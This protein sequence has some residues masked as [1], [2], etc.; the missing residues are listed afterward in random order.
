MGGL[1]RATDALFI[2]AVVE[3]SKDDACLLEPWSPLFYRTVARDTALHG[4]LNVEVQPCE[5]PKLIFAPE[6]LFLS[7]AVNCGDEPGLVEGDTTLGRRLRT[8]ALLGEERVRRR[9][10]IVAHGFKISILARFKCEAVVPF[11]VTTVLALPEDIIDP[12]VLQTIGPC[13]LDLHVVPIQA[14][15]HAKCIPPANVR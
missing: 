2:L 7:L 4:H 1:G 5:R 13:A 11:P 15:R 3:R 8:E 6:H 12:S 9:L 10:V 14:Q